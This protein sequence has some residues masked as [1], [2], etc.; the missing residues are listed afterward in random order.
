MPRR[1]KVVA[2]TMI[3]VAVGSSAL[4]VIERTAVSAVVLVAGAVGVW[5]VLVRVPTRERV[6][7]ERA[8]AQSPPERA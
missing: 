3:V 6:L 2:V 5:W 8:A 1:A 7:A 4:V